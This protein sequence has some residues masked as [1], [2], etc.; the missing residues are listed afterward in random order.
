MH[1]RDCVLAFASRHTAPCNEEAGNVDA[2]PMRVTAQFGVGKPFQGQ[3][4]TRA[5]LKKWKL[6]FTRSP[7]RRFDW[8]ANQASPRLTLMTEQRCEMVG[9]M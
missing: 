6:A 7:I 2:L 3:R 4:T 8:S 9:I 1:F 5:M